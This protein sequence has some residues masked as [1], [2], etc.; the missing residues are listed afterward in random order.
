MK[1]EYLVWKIVIRKKKVSYETHKITKFLKLSKISEYIKLHVK[2]TYM[3]D[4][5]QRIN[6]CKK[7]YWTTIMIITISIKTSI[8]KTWMVSIWVKL[9]QFK[10]IKKVW[11][12]I[13]NIIKPN[14]TYTCTLYTYQDKCW[15]LFD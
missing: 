7:K 3:Y 10:K 9:K 5:L 4:G 8:L 2:Y 13:T 1:I 11:S 6:H 15:L 12:A 14:L